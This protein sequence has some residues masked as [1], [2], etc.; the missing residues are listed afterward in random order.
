VT[1]L[2]RS[3][4]EQRTPAAD[5][6]PP[7]AGVMVRRVGEATRLTIELTRAGQGM[8]WLFWLLLPVAFGALVYQLDPLMGYLA[9]GM[10]A[11]LVLTILGIGKLMDRKRKH[12]QRAIWIDRERVWIEQPDIR[13]DPTLKFMRRTVSLIARRPLPDA[14]A[15][16][17]SLPRRA[18]EQVRVDQY[19]DH[20]SDGTT[21]HPR[22]VIEGDAGS[23]EY[24]AAQ[25]DRKNLEWIRDYLRFRLT[26]RT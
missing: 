6:G 13:N 3:L 23:I 7:R 21:Y 1:E 17:R 22:L 2:D 16:L 9:A 4:R 8:V 24:I 20:D 19:A 26:S 18:V 5:P 25:F 11:V 10:A 14:P 15:P 12:D